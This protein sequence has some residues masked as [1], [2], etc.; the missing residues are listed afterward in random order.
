MH[1]VT[2][3]VI[4][5][6]YC[7]L[8]AQRHRW[9]V[10]ENFQT[11]FFKSVHIRHPISDVPGMILMRP[12]GDRWDRQSLTVLIVE[13]HLRRHRM[14]QHVVESERRVAGEAATGVP[15]LTRP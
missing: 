8:R 4:G 13:R 14:A 3:T 10:I 7:F 12:E 5:V 1:V 9:P 11:A 6:G 2:Q 15:N